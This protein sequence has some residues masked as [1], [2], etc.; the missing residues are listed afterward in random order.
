MLEELFPRVYRR[1][2]SLPVLG[3]T[4]NGFVEFLFTRGYPR[5]PV[6]RHVRTTRRVDARLQRRGCRSADEITR[7]ELRACAPPPGRSQDDINLAATVRQLERYLDERGILPPNRPPSAA[8]S[9]VAEYGAYLRE[10]RGLAR[11]TINHHVATA[12]QFIA[13][14][15]DRGGVSHLPNL[16]AQDLEGFVRCSGNRVSRGSLQH[17]VAQARSFLRFLATKG[18]A[19]T[20]L[21]TRID[22]PRVYRGEQLPRA[23]PWSTVRA[24]LKAI[25]RSTPMGLRDY[26]MLL[27]IATYGLRTSEV[28]GLR[29][30]H[31]EW[32]TSRLN[33]HQPK[34]TAPLLL[35][36]TDT[37][38]HHV[39][40]YL[41]CGR[42]SVPYREVF[43]RH[44]APAGV[45]KP[46]AVT[47]V[48]QAWSRR[49]SL[50]IPFQGPHCMRHSYAVH[51]LRQGTPL[52]TIGDL[53]GHRTAES[54]CVYLRLA[55]E[56]LRSVPLNLP[57]SVSQEVSP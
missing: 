52:K 40:E 2:S 34:T 16:T 4:L 56:D 19:P 51:L 26:A 28:V 8:E 3:A 31:I 43:V 41:R 17:V 46:T 23:L 11:S 37:V 38:G 15:D 45:L 29:L 18:E 55:V 5:T 57:T 12:A 7:T 35:P 6:R 54:T 47:E 49:S 50:S 1:Y 32:S 10:V 42:P 13:H 39:R 20:G 53:L 21:D 22:T 25:D 44:R 33:V 27:L 14:L 24:L 9:K 36:L 30:E 48:F